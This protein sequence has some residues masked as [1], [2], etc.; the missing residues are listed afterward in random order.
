MCDTTPV[1]SWLL[2]ALAMIVGAIGAIITAAA[3]N[4]SILLAP[5][6]P[7]PMM[8]AA[9]LTAVGV[10]F[11][12]LALGALDVLCKCAGNRCAGQCA[13]LRNLVNAAKTVLGIQALACLTA[14]LYAWIPFV[15]QPSMWVII[16]ALFIQLALIISAI[17]FLRNLS[18][19]VNEANKD[20][21]SPSQPADQKA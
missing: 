12:G 18:D 14:A 3:L 2:A 16:G 21:T 20:R 13:N 11:C 4:G 9:A 6:S 19:C 7:I 17:V 10:L 5:A 8:I 1:R 15:G